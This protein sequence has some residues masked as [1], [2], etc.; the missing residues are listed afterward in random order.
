MFMVNLQSWFVPYILFGSSLRD[1]EGTAFS[2]LSL[3]PL[4]PEDS[5]LMQKRSVCWRRI[6]SVLSC[7][8]NDEKKVMN[9]G[10]SQL[11]KFH[12]PVVSIQI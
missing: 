7:R 9:P 3:P 4:S 1:T 12:F 8:L 11:N 2:N 5:L 6:V 10:G